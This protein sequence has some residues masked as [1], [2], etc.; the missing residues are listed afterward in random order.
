MEVIETD[1]D[2]IQYLIYYVSK[3]KSG[4]EKCETEVVFTSPD[5]IIDLVQSGQLYK[6]HIFWN[7]GID[8][9]ATLPHNPHSY[10][11]KSYLLYEGEFVKSPAR[12]VIGKGGEIYF[13]PDHYKTF[14]RVDQ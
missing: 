5:E 9:N 14:Q 3:T 10:Y 2:T 4:W 7:L 13:S 6:P 1:E 12:I 8:H 11:Y